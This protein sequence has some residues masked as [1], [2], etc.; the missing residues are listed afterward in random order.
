MDGRRYVG[1][2]PHFTGRVMCV[3]HGHSVWS[4]NETWGPDLLNLQQAAS[5]SFMF[6]RLSRLESSDRRENVSS[7]EESSVMK[8]DKGREL[9]KCFTPWQIIWKGLRTS[10]LGQICARARGFS[11]RINRGRIIGGVGPLISWVSVSKCSSSGT[12]RY[13]CL[14]S[15]F[16][17]YVFVPSPYTLPVWWIP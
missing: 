14:S 3:H 16:Y 15:S 9:R 17:R 12:V 10:V 4:H 13:T 5:M 1:L 11:L 8:S 2:S 6:I 7:L